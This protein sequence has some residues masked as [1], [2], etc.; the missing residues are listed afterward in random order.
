M[1]NKS[2]TL[3]MQSANGSSDAAINSFKQQTL[4]ACQC[5]IQENFA[6]HS[7]DKLDFIDWMPVL[8]VI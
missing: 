7:Q 3:V 8:L 5:C 4:A 6:D 1:F 2:G